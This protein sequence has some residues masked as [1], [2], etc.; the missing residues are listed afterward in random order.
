MN[1]KDITEKLPG[2][3]VLPT[4]PLRR[5]YLIGAAGLLL[6]AL[7]G[8]WSVA[9][10]NDLTLTDGIW[11]FLGLFALV[12]A[13][14]FNGSLR[15]P[16]FRGIS[17]VAE[18]GNEQTDT[19]NAVCGG[20]SGVD[21]QSQLESCTRELKAAAEA[22]GLTLAMQLHDNTPR[23]IAGNC[24]SFCAVLCILLQNAIKHSGHGGIE[25]NI[26]TLE[27]G[28]GSV[29]LRVE[30]IDHGIGIA[31]EQQSRIFREEIAL[32][33]IRHHTPQHNLTSA[34]QTVEG[35]GGRIGVH[36]RLGEGSTFWFT[37]ILNKP[38]QG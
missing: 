8:L 23:K 21:L 19:D 29:L 14:L 4:R 3:K 36:S 2:G 37:A 17:G 9:N 22:K 25:I 34:R 12:A 10:V 30:V 7:L 13:T 26:K 18:A 20:D 24:E 27:Q 5:A 38:T 35:L 16:F 32:N 28:H 33:S 11:L 31:R 15:K 1:Q 6:G